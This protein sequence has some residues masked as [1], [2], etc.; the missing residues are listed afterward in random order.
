MMLVV[1]YSKRYIEDLTSFIYER[2]EIDFFRCDRVN[3]KSYLIQI[4]S[5]SSDRCLSFSE[6]SDLSTKGKGEHMMKETEN[7]VIKMQTKKNGKG[8]WEPVEARTEAESRLLFRVP[9]RT[10]QADILP[11]HLKYFKLL[12]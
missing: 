4:Q 5:K 12:S 11:S 3:M 10:N 1:F 2:S 7:G 8:C 9:R 6:E